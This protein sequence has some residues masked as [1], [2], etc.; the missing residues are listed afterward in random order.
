MQVLS[1][2]FAAVLLVDV[3][4]WAKIKKKKENREEEKNPNIVIAIMS[5]C[6][7]QMKKSKQAVHTSVL[8]LSAAY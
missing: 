1:A 2:V 5:F 7:G 8:I 4:K 6:C 3:V